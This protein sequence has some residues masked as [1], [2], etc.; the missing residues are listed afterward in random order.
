MKFE[1][2]GET[3]SV[4]GIRQLGADNSQDFREQI[5]A[6]L[7]EKFR[8]IEIDL[9]QTIFLDSCGLGVLISL[10]KTAG[11]RNGTVRLLNPTPRVQRLFH[12]TRMHKIFEIIHS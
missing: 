6:A 3:L 9:S 12:V 4:V 10:R 1:I 5:Q 2:K 7:P 8:H 11:S